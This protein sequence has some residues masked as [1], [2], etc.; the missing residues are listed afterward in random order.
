MITKPLESHGTSA[1]PALFPYVP[2]R[3][4]SLLPVSGSSH[5]TW[6]E[7][8]LK[9]KKALVLFYGH[10][11]YDC[12]CNRCTTCVQ[13]PWRLK[14]DVGSSGTGVTDNCELP[15]GCWDSNPDSL[16]KQQVLLTTK[17]SLQPSETFRF[18]EKEYRGQ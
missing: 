18:K 17:P 14:E 16:K 6:K 13:Y 9:K 4:R 12:M 7:H 2:V 5:T 15:C 3:L 8:T 1:L 10:Q 11:C